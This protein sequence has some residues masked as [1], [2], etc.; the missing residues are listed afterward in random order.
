MFLGG[1]TGMENS[2]RPILRSFFWHLS[3]RSA[4]FR[5]AL[6]KWIKQQLSLVVGCDCVLKARCSGS[7][8]STLQA[9][10]CCRAQQ[11]ASRQAISEFRQ[12]MVCVDNA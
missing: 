12:L 11:C 5:R 9:L 1:D 6:Y 8:T 7:G 3:F 10:A 4:N 2:V